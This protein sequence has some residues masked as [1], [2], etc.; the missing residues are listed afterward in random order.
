MNKRYFGEILLL[1]VAFFL[2]GYLVRGTFV[3]TVTDAMV[4]YLIL[5]VPQIL[6]IIYIIWLQKDP[7]LATFGFVG[8]RGFDWLWSCT[9]FLILWLLYLAIGFSITLLPDPSRES[10]TSGYSWRL[11][12]LSRLP[13]ALIFAIATGYKEEL[14]YRAYLLTRSDA[15]K[16]PYWMAVAV[17]SVVF[18]LGHVYQGAAAVIFAMLQGILFSVFFLKRRNIHSIAIAHSMYNFSVLLLSAVLPDIL[19]I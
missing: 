18:A 2:P 12:G 16:V 17:S 19:P 10:I 5:S 3:T 1:F 7:P 9:L 13:L 14:F 8:M 4:Q 6:L 11:P 15:L